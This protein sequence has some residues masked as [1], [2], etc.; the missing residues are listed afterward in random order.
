LI[1]IERIRRDEFPITRSGIYMDNAT[2]GPLPNRHL[3]AVNDFMQQMSAEGLR[4]LFRI[5]ADGVD[6]VRDKAAA[7]LQCDPKHIC[8]VRNTGQ[9][10]NLV[11]QGVQWQ[12]GDEVVLY[13]L[14]HPACIFPWLNLSDRGLE[15]RFVRDRGRFG[16]DPGD[17]L[18]LIGPRTRA[19]CVSLVNFA[20]G[21]RS[22]VEDIAAFCRERDIWFVVDAVQALGVLRV[23]ASQI[24]ADVIV[25]HGYKFLLSGFG[26]GIC[27]CSD[28]AI[29]DLRVREV[30][31]NSVKNPF[32]LDRI[33][34]FELD[35]AT[36]AKRFEPSFQP[37]PQV[38]GMAATLD[39]LHEVGAQAIEEHV[40]SLTGRLIA[41]LLEKG[42]RVVGRQAVHAE[43]AI[44]SV[45]LRDD[46]ER[47]RVEGALRQCQVACAVRESRVRLSPHFYN[48]DDEVDRLLSCL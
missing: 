35:F 21:A 2:L 10:V 23:D 13:E 44:I 26:I 38:F 6:Q 37:L 20:H 45:A 1:D 30:G 28:R 22:A 46:A 3:R 36:G 32:D 39:L 16:F 47:Q 17:V 24:G 15:V 5:S 29:A 14:D 41:G 48:T 33:L 43:S 25:A 27:Y 42:F 11:A 12:A 8:F 34:D 19:V 9:G 40:L 18:E 7:L 31:W 4:D